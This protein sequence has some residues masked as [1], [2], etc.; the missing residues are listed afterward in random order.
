MPVTKSQFVEVANQIFTEFEDFIEDY[1]FFEG[2]TVDRFTGESIPNNEQTVPGIET[3]SDLT[4]FGDQ[5]IQIGDK[6]IIFKYKDF[7]VIPE[8]GNSE[9][10]INGLNYRVANSFIDPAKATVIIKAREI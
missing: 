10:E 7:D 4:Q 3:N 9:M 8:I 1:S 2:K 5:D 6:V